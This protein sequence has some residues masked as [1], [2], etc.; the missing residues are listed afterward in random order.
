MRQEG[1]DTLVIETVICPNPNEVWRGGKGEDQRNYK[2][3]TNG[4]KNK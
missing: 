4:G 2:V 1:A 3:A